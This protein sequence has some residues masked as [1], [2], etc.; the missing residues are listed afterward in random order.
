MDERD[1]SKQPPDEGSGHD[2]PV[3]EGQGADSDE[4]DE[5]AGNPGSEGQDDDGQATGNPKSAG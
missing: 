5:Q 3:D 1:P 2:A 4:A